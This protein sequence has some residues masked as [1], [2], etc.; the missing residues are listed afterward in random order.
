[1]EL[2]VD[3]TVRPL[4]PGVEL[5]AYRILQEAL[6]NVAKHAPG[7]AASVTLHYRADRLGLEVRNGPSP[8][9]GRAAGG[10]APGRGVRGMRERAALH[11]GHLEATARP[12]GGFT[13][14]A[15]LP[16]GEFR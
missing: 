9:P 8:L 4:S 6:T 7:A 3:G 10:A 15:V 16:Y 2:G 1:V 14:T 12:G 5:S 11:H 13:V